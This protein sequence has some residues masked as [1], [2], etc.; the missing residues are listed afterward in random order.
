MMERAQDE[1]KPRPAVTKNMCSAGKHFL[2]EVKYGVR[3]KA[4]RNLVVFTNSFV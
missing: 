2:S 3:Q 4:V 1:L